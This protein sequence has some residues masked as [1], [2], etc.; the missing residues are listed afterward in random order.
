MNKAGSSQSWYTKDCKARKKNLRKCSK[1]LSTFPFDTNKRQK[2]VK[3][4]AE[5]KKICRKAE[6]AGRRQL[7]NELIQMGQNDPRLFWN[8]IKKWIIGDKRN[9]TY[10]II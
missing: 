8:T 10:R 3:A 6:S 9:L 4:R 5:Y 2:F 7:M 1:D